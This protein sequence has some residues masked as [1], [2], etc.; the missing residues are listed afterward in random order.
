MRMRRFRR[1]AQLIAC[2]PQSGG[3]LG[4]AAAQMRSLLMQCVSANAIHAHQLHSMPDFMLGPPRYPAA[5]LCSICHYWSSATCMTCGEPYCS[6]ACAQV[7]VRANQPFRD[8]L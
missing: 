2:R 6:R 4:H 1:T 3:Y 8:A 5:P 7:C